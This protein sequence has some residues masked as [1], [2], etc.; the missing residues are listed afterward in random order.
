MSTLTKPAATKPA[1]AAITPRANAEVF[2]LD[3]VSWEAYSTLRDSLDANGR[4][5]IRL[6][7]DAG[8]L[9]LMA[10]GICHEWPKM[11]LD[12]AVIVLTQEF[13]I[14]RRCLGSTTFRKEAEEKGFEPDQCYYLRK[15]KLAP[16]RKWPKRSADAAEGPSPDLTIEVDVTSS[17]IDRLPLHAAWGVGEVWR[18]DEHAERVTI[19]LLEGRDYKPGDS[20]LFPGLKAELLSEALQFDAD[21]EEARMGQFRGLVRTRLRPSAPQNQ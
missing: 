10:P 8:R 18:V 2:S 9:D 21:D 13:G 6:T 12:R 15:E 20:G 5:N 14:P 3:G 17:S 4:C 7:Y 11:A 1:P 16:F 19:L